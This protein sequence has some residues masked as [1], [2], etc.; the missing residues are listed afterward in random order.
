[1]LA[2]WEHS[3]SMMW[4]VLF[5]K[6]V[7]I[8]RLQFLFVFMSRTSQKR[9]ERTSSPLQ[10]TKRSSR[11]ETR[12]RWQTSSLEERTSWPRFARRFAMKKPRRRR[13]T[14]PSRRKRSSVT[15]LTLIC[16]GKS[17]L[18]FTAWWE[19]VCLFVIVFFMFS[20][21]PKV[22]FK[23]VKSLLV[24][25]GAIKN[26][27][28]LKWVNCLH[29]SLFIFIKIWPFNRLY[30]ARNNDTRKIEKLGTFL[31]IKKKWD[32]TIKKQSFPN[33]YSIHHSQSCF[34][35]CNNEN[36]MYGR[37]TLPDRSGRS[38]YSSKI[39]IFYFWCILFFSC[40]I[41]S[42]FSLEGVSQYVS[43]WN[44]N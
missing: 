24:C 23:R 10:L 42:L 37:W 32:R 44:G 3:F 31:Q 1:M 35:C 22:S 9:L 18:L 27:V 28:C 21:V 2:F 20:F 16:C 38:L 6:L 43:S 14:S 13:D 19:V 17:T 36:E 39:N 40:I 15:S 34:H 26:F 11:S 25:F 8:I 33:F 41:S 5:T 29:N 4:R 30:H 12:S 7:S